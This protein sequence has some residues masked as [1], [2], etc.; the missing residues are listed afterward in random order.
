MS[1]ESKRQISSKRS[2]ASSTSSSKVRRVMA[3]W[4]QVIIWVL[5][6]AFIAG[7]ALWALAVNYN[8]ASSA[9]V[10]R[11]L[12][13]TIGYL[14]VDGTAT[15]NENYWVFP[16][17]IEQAY[18]DL[19]AQYGSPSLDPAIEEPY[20]KT[21]IA[22]DQLSS[23][24]TLYYAE[25]EKIKP[26]SK[27]VNEAVK[28]EI[29]AINK[30]ATKSQ[31]I[32]VQYGSI[33]NYEKEL[34]KQKETELT[35]Q[36]VKDKLGV[37]TE[38][39]IKKYYDENQSDLIANYTKAETQYATFETKEEMNKF[40]TLAMQK[41]ISQAATESSVTLNDYT[42]TPGTFSEDIEKEIF[43]AT[44]TIISFPYNDAYFVFNIKS[45]QKVDTY[46]NF[47]NSEAY[48]EAVSTLQNQKFSENIKKW[49]DEKKVSFEFRDPV[50]ASWYT[51]LSTEDKDLL[52]VYKKFYEQI[53]NENDEVRID[54]AVEQ[55]AAFL[56]IADRIAASTD[57]TFDPVRQDVK[58]FE[59]KVVESVYQQTKGSSQEIL[60]RMK[61]YYPERNDI[62]FQYY[63]KLYDAIKPYL[64]IGGAYY[65][66]NELFEVYQGFSDLAESTSTDLQMRSDSY[67]KLYEMNKLLGDPQTAGYYLDKL[68]EIKPDYS[69]N[70]DTAQKELEDMLAQQ[71]YQMYTGDE[72]E[73]YQDSE[74]TETN[75]T[76]DTN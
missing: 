59:K 39:E 30:D 65:V 44:S 17:E 40:V 36:A 62:S 72:T 34:K 76:E 60:R 53:F 3:R 66:M 5:A 19:L 47:K 28:A 22:V 50:Y 12:E 57:T 15:K 2:G 45:V 21:L 38:D 43:D 13:E 9:K 10:K 55:Q 33:S 67:Y 74:N 51:A 54:V 52:N 61:D 31:Q 46:D 26:D 7:I 71:Q 70:F 24:V 49:K 48:S 8:P 6:I 35:I 42:V 68:Q 29:D 37:V 69:I 63:S 25:V 23:K 58:M 18:G 73:T 32:K 27:K 11:T 64:S 16:E 1:K 14:T 75:S 4:Q 41:G 56:V 20:L